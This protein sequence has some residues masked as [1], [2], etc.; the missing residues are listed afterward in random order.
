[1]ILHSGT[2]DSKLEDGKQIEMS[3]TTKNLSRKIFLVTS[4]GFIVF[5]LAFSFKSYVNHLSRAEQQLLDELY[6]IASTASLM[7]DGNSHQQ[8]TNTYKNIDDIKR[9]EQDSNYHALYTS[10]KEIEQV[11]GLESP[12]Y[13][14]VRSSNDKKYELIATSSDEPYFRHIYSKSPKYLDENF[15]I[16]GKIE[17]YN[18]ATGTWASAFAPIKND[19]QEVLGVV[20]VDKNFETFQAAAQREFLEDIAIALLIFVFIAVFLLYALRRLTGQIET[21]QTSLDD[22]NKNLT[23]EIVNVRETEEKLIS[24]NRRIQDEAQRDIGLLEERFSQIF[25]HSNDGIF[26]LDPMNDTIL[27][28]NPA[29]CK[30]LKYEKSE[31]LKKKMTEIH[32]HEIDNLWGFCND[33]FRQGSGWTDE[34]SCYTRTGQYVPAE[35]SA[36]HFSDDDK[37]Y[38]VAMV[39][40]VSQ[41]VQSR[42]ELENLNEKLEE[43]VKNRTEEL[44][45]TNEELNDA[46]YELKKT[47]NELDHFLYKV[48]HDFR[49]PLLSVLGLIHLARKENVVSTDIS[50]RYF[51]LIEGSIIKLD[52]LNGEITTLVKSQRT[53]ISVKQID[54]KSLVNSELENLKFQTNEKK[55]QWTICIDDEDPFASDEFRIGMILHNIMY[56]AV[57]YSDPYKHT[58]EA[59]VKILTNESSCI[60]QISDNGIG[61]DDSLKS[62]VFEMFFRATE[63]SSGSGLGLY[64]VKETVN[65][66]DGDIR[67]SSKQGVGSTFEISLPNLYHPNLPENID[68]VL[69]PS[70]GD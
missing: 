40:D 39:R 52:R 31:L 59:K 14:I 70:E 6:A 64:I 9:I 57:K 58:A 54:F 34:L 60:I 25:N 65:K 33:I 44:T 26:I 8:L 10:L 67:V 46:L 69:I 4:I 48:T 28:V 13:T 23:E 62:R 61:I 22:T 19:L 24:D 55:I 29:A 21:I 45:A 56:N 43:R 41:R 27:D 63:S 42:R 7:I 36:S 17:C 11:N 37:H 12:I 16:G 66:L 18:T 30:L 49:A 50:E 15:E 3:Q 68:T 32:H 38:M 53:G 1:M 47:N 35:I 2:I 51:D 20:Q 5:L